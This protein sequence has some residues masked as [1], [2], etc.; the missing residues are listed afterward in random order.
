MFSCSDILQFVFFHLFVCWSDF[1]VFQVSGFLLFLHILE[2]TINSVTV[3]RLPFFQ[4]MCFP[5]Y[6]LPQSEE[7]EQNGFY[8]LTALVFWLHKL[9]IERRLETKPADISDISSLWSKQEE[10]VK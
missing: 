3:E 2:R 1:W 4:H 6:L 7:L 10:V 5:I 9:W 8:L